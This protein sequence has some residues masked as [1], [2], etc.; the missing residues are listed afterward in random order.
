MRRR[1][2]GTDQICVVK[3]PTDTGASLA[4]RHSRAP[5]DRGREERKKKEEKREKKEEEKRE[6]VRVRA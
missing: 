4:C 3:L 1:A 2:A 6:G 5:G